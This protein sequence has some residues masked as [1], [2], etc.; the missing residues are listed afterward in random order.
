MCGFIQ[1]REGQRGQVLMFLDTS[2]ILE[3]LSENAASPLVKHIME[4]IEGNELFIS[5]IQLGEISDWCFLNGHDPDF[6]VRNITTIVHV[7]P[8]DNNLVVRGSRLKWDMRSVGHKKFSLIDGII[9][10][11]ARKLSEPLLTLDS[12]FRDL[13]D[14]ILLSG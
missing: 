4:R 6:V 13:D 9:L 2:V 5:I 11:S 12:D 8:L 10:A 14:V 7:Y 3:L 1:V